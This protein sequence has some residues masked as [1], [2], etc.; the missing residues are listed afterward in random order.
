[1]EQISEVKVPVWIQMGSWV[2]QNLKI[3][4]HTPEP[5]NNDKVKDQKGPSMDPNGIVYSIPK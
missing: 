5:D 4:V 2:D 1:M 3:S